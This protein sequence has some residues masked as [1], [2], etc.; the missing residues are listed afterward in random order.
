MC[1][2]LSIQ[3][4]LSLFLLAESVTTKEKDF[5]HHDSN[6]GQQNDTYSVKTHQ[7]S[8]LGVQFQK[9]KNIKREKSNLLD[10]PKCTDH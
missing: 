2:T 5:F 4:A 6:T 8:G 3:I 9:I 1:I 10:H 7:A